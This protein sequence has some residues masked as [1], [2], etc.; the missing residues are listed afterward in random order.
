MSPAISTA[1]SG[2]P[3]SGTDAAPYF[4]VFNPAAQAAKFDPDAAYVRRWV[5]EFGGAD[6]PE[7]I[8]DHGRERAEALRRYGQIR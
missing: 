6:Y 3:G 8:V 1:G 2:R 4:R 7:P 5:P